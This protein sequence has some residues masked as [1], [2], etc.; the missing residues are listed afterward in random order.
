MY[1]LRLSRDTELVGHAYTYIRENLLRGLTHSIMT[2][3]MSHDE[4]FAGYR[5]WAAS[6][7]T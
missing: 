1:Q 6:S 7:M 4:S 2:A 3:E 5:T